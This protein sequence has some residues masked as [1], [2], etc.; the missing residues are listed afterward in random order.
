[1]HRGGRQEKV[2][3]KALGS[4]EWLRALERSIGDRISW[5]VIRIRFFALVSGPVGVLAAERT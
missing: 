1:M 4:M 5:H 3:A 2:P